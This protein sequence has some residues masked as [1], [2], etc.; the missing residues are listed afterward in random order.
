MD[1]HLTMD[2]PNPS[3]RE[4]DETEEV[5]AM[6]KPRNHAHDSSLTID[7]GSPFQLLLRALDQW[8]PNI[9]SDAEKTEFAED[10][11]EL[12][13][14][15]ANYAGI[16]R[17]PRHTP[18]QLPGVLKQNAP[19]IQEALA[20]YSSSKSLEPLVNLLYNHEVLVAPP[21]IAESRSGSQM[22]ID[23]KV[24]ERLYKQLLTLESLKEKLPPEFIKRHKN[25]SS[26]LELHR[27]LPSTASDDLVLILDDYKTL[28]VAHGASGCDGDSEVSS[29]AADEGTAVSQAIKDF[30]TN[31]KLS[32]LLD[33]MCESPPYTRSFR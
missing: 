1:E 22:D 33:I 28:A 31:G 11:A 4:L 7:I 21:I 32:K 30:H 26:L 27:F 10:F 8:Y 29:V 17:G 19:A 13:L 3:K 5:I 16:E 9:K 2:Q 25:F 23:L 20:A 14:F 18:D 15:Y 24:N 12:Y 6:K